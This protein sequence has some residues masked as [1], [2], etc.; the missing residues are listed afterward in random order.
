MSESTFGT[1]SQFETTEIKIDGQDVRGIFSSLSVF[2]DIYR[3]CVTG[4][5][6]IMDSDGAKFI[7]E[8][9][10]EFIEP[11]TFKFKAANGEMLE[12]EGVL[13]GLRNES[14]VGAI[15]TY[16]ID[17]TSESVRKNEQT[18]VTNSYKETNPEEIVKE[19]V[20]KVGGTLETNARGKQMNYLGSRKRPV[21]I[22]K[23]VLTHGLTQ[24]TQATQNED[25]KEE[26]AKGTTGFLCWETMKGFKFESIKDVLEG[27]AG[28]QH[29]D[30]KTRLV[31][32]SL[33]MDELMKSIVQIEF[34]QIGDFQTKLR[35]GAFGSKLVS[36]D[37]DTGEYK[38]Y[39]FYNGQSMTKKQIEALPEGSI[40]RFYCKPISNQKFTNGCPIAQ[41]LTGDQ[42]R[43]YLAQNS[44]QQNTFSDQTGHMTLYPQFQFS[45]GDVLD[46]QISKVKDE[47]A[48]GGYDK[49]H[50]GKYIL[51][52]VAHHFFNEGRAYTKVKTIRSTTQQDEVS[53][54]KS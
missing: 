51:Q 15:K 34:K 27:K 45:A 6:V 42:S 28:E 33:G 41:P 36:F 32:K 23:Y 40:T 53:A 30:Y 50:S 5:I 46:C 11:I 25:S 2:E 43:G 29:S 20:Q 14:V 37:A 18:F 21:D 31:N 54:A 24:E 8:Q 9:R 47:E 12:F 44:G 22:I 1:P 7:E 35:S 4:N 17:F 3:P 48:D 38:E 13:N 19:M 52:A 16:C 39:Y 26:E 10:I 49:K